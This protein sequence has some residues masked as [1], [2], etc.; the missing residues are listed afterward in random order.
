[1]SNADADLRCAR[2]RLSETRTQVVPGAGDSSA[3]L[4][5]IGEAPGRDEDL[6]GAPFVGRAGKVLD[7]A[8]AHAGISRDMIYITNLVKCRP[9]S[10][11]RPKDDEVEACAKH[12]EAEMG[13]IHP[14][15]VCLL[16]QTVARNL[17][18][19]DSDMRSLVGKEFLLSIGGK[20]VRAFVA[21]HPAACLYR[22]E[23][24]ES[25]RETVRRCVEAAGLR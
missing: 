12:L 21:Y 23:N 11:R 8:L 1:M 17:L 10:N 13:A 25:L 22:R 5:F 6:K 3:A 24:V 2:C 18:G 4:V 15:I 7:G 20:K 16:G 14:K 19:C 9:P